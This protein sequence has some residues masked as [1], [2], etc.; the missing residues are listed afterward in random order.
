[1]TEPILLF[2]ATGYTGRLVATELAHRGLTFAI[3]GRNRERLEE[4]ASRLPSRPGII[5]ASVDDEPS[6]RSA[7]RGRKAVLNCAGP[8]TLLGEPVVRAAIEAGVH[9]ADSTGELPFMR[10]IA[11]QFNVPARQRGL[12]VV[13]AAAYEVAL[14]DCAAA[15]L[16]KP[17]EVYDEV[18]VLYVLHRVRPSQGTARSA[19]EVLRHGGLGYRNAQ[20]VRERP[21]REFRRVPLPVDPGRVLAVSFPSG[22]IASVPL[23]IRTRTVTTL[24]ALPATFAL[25]AP[26]VAP[27]LP[28]L[29]RL[30]NPLLKR[31]VERLPE[32]PSD[33]QRSATTYVISVRLKQGNRTQQAIVQGSDMYAT[34]AA[35]M[36]YA[37]QRFIEER[38]LTAGVVAPTQIFSPEAFFQEMHSHC[39]LAD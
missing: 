22:E 7:M 30:A 28:A 31:L 3:A 29:T 17:A 35:V 24:M 20:W 19:L 26:L 2:G 34:T 1:M 5:E 23:H 32:G 14:A 15:H 4:L 8:F 37:A 25:G 12:S 16:A 18:E 21:A 38:G 36:A 13:P 10:R 9:Y 39:V 11:E 27:M 33:E 6:L